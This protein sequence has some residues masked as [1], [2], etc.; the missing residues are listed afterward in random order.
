MPAIDESHWVVA[1]RRKVPLKTAGIL[2]PVLT[3]ACRLGDFAT[4]PLNRIVVR[5]T[6]KAGPGVLQVVPPPYRHLLVDRRNLARPN[7]TYYFH[8]TGMPSCDVFVDGETKPR[9]LDR[10][11][12]TSLPPPDPNALKKRQ[13]L[14]AGWRK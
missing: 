13:A 9:L 8:D 1:G 2:D 6:D 3:S 14:I 12:G 4:L 11:R 7:E 10:A 5:F